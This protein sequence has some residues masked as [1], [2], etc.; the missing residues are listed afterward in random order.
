M[1]RFVKINQIRII[2][3]M[4]E[5]STFTHSILKSSHD[6]QQ[7]PACIDITKSI[8]FIVVKRIFS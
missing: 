1:G 8:F 5:Y 2:K 7:Q 6:N 4:L 3:N